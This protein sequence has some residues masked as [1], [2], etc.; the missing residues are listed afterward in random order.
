LNALR[1]LRVA[2]EAAVTTVF[3][4]VLE[5]TNRFIVREQSSGA[6]A[7]DA[8]RELQPDLI[9]LDK[10][11]N[12]M[13]GE[14]VAAMFQEDPALRLI[15]IGFCTGELSKTEAAEAPAPT[16]HN[17]VSPSELLGLVDDLLNFNAACVDCQVTGDCGRAPH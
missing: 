17:P 7:L 1:I 13:N 6:D 8:A 12:G 5:D 3:Q 14:E 2:D 15:P 10:E 16:L 9:L 4:I 11:I